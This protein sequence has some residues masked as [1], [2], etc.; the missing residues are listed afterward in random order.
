MRLPLGQLMQRCTRVHLEN[1][2]TV[3]VNIAMQIKVE[4]RMNAGNNDGLRKGRAK[5]ICAKSD[6]D[7]VVVINVICGDGG[8]S[9]IG[10]GR[11]FL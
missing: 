4:C 9:F 7:T 8:N 3:S 1:L 6:G 5:W 2:T 11:N 10:R